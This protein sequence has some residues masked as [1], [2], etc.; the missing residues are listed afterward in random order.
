MVLRWQRRGRVGRR[1]EVVSERPAYAGRFLVSRTA[2][3]YSPCGGARRGGSGPTSAWPTWR[4]GR[5]PP[6]PGPGGWEGVARGD[7]G[8]R[9]EVVSERPAHAG[10]FL[11]F[12]TAAA[13]SACGGARQGGSGPTAAWPK[14]PSKRRDPPWRPP[15]PQPPRD[16]RGSPGVPRQMEGERTGPPWARSLEQDSRKPG[17]GGTVESRVQTPSL[18]RT[19]N[20]ENRRFANRSKRFICPE[21]PWLLYRR[22]RCPSE[23]QDMRKDEPNRNWRRG[24]AAR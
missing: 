6:S 22:G 15:F 9:R 1:R 2:A 10:R 8:R 4:G 3:A 7:A 18:P 24:D 20:G 13:C 19:G 23:R 17:A 14:A 5:V 21:A 16:P 11:V 12:R